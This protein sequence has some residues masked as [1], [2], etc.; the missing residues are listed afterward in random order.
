M[1][2]SNLKFRN[3]QEFDYKIV[4]DLTR[5]AFWNHHV[6]GCDEHYLV[7]IMR[8]SKAFIK[9]LDIIVL[10]D[11]KIVANIIY[12][13]AII[14]DDNE[15]KHNVISFGPISVLPEYQGH[16]IGTK[17]IEHTKILAQDLGYKAILIY[18]DPDFYSKVGF[19]PAKNLGIATKD[20]MYSVA[21]QACELIKDALSNC[22]GRFFEDSIYHIDEQAA[23]EFDKSFP[24]KDYVSN[25][26]SQ[27][28]FLKLV[29]MS[30]PRKCISPHMMKTFEE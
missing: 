24:K 18:G 13:K 23:K 4:E 5:E 16:G 3:E 25:L 9:E 29:N 21:L 6:L 19:I 10:L 30:H 20:N 15:K 1:D 7:H 12:T 11:N 22:S 26:P 27:E 17:L 28:R 2:I 8:D 14:L